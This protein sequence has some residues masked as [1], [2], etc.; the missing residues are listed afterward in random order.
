[1]KK[2]THKCQKS[3]AISWKA[4]HYCGGIFARIL[5]SRKVYEVFHVWGLRMR[6]AWRWPKRLVVGKICYSH[7]MFIHASSQFLYNWWTKAGLSVKILAATIE[8]NLAKGGTHCP[9][10]KLGS[11]VDRFI[12]D[13]MYIHWVI[14][15]LKSYIVRLC[16][17]AFCV[18]HS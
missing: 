2:I 11:Y 3:C 6:Q 13:I 12:A 5:C 1:M 9:V 16:I 17:Y 4:T 18:N 10:A 7:N 8:E 15:T 14:S